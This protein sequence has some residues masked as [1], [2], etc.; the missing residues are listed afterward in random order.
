MSRHGAGRRGGEHGQARRHRRATAAIDADLTTSTT[1]LGDERR[2]SGGGELWTTGGRSA[3][4]AAS[5]STRL[6]T[7][8]RRS[9]AVLSAALKRGM[10]AEG[11][12]TGGTD[13]GRKGWGV[14]LRVTF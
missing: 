11:E 7:A 4:A 14:A 1:V 6:A 13:Q 2:I 5:A 10:Y 12:L 9:A 8:G 3:C